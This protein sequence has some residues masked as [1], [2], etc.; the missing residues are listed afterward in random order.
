MAGATIAPGLPGLL[1]QFSDH[2]DAEY[3]SRFILTI[4]GLAIAISAPIAGIL[5]DKFGRRFLLHFGV[6][7]YIVAGSGGLWLSDLYLL[8]ISRVLLGVAVGAVMVCS[9]ALLTDH[10]QGGERERAMGIQ[11]SAMS[12][13]GIVFVF[14]GAMLSD[15]SWRAPFA[16]Y[17]L[18]LILIPLIYKFVSK[19]P[20]RMVEPG[21]VDGRFPV[22]HA[23]FIYAIGFVTMVFFYLIPSQ[24]PFLAIELGAQSL[25]YA[26]FAV[27][28]SQFFAAVAAMNYQRIKSKFTNQQI[29]LFSFICMSLGFYLMSQISSLL[30]MFLCTPFIGFGLGLNFPN[31]NIWLM[32][33]VPQ[34]MRGRASGGLTMSIFLGQFMSPFLSLPLVQEYGLRGAFFGTT[35]IMICLVVL[36]STLM[37]IRGKS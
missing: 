13:G 15:V 11:A 1:S 17:L 32:S 9:M 26:G 3:L 27:V 29:L 10:F 18:P 33:K 34:T 5:A 23:A 28:L 35:L 6:V 21:A 16:V 12:A 2:P 25:K 8:L 37:V 19:P 36:P 4:P 22:K 31:M 7:L 20:P 30:G 14:A 24:L